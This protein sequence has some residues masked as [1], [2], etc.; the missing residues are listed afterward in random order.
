MLE[1]SRRARLRQQPATRLSLSSAFDRRLAHRLVFVAAVVAGALAVRP[2]HAGPQWSAS[3]NPGLCVESSDERRLVFCGDLHGDLI[4]GRERERD[5][6]A[7]PYLKLGT[8]A[9]DD[10]RA[11]GGASLHLPTWDDLALVLSAGPM[12]DH[13]GRFGLDSSIFFGV[14]SF[15]FHGAYN[16]GGGLVAFAQRDFSE[17]PVTVI[18][19]GLRVDVFFLAAPALLGWGALQ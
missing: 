11:A 18:G 15:N 16:F 10:L 5:L 3:A 9:F 19:L 17:Q 13:R 2:V 12:L 6:G 7:G 1:L 4:L 14:R 8:V